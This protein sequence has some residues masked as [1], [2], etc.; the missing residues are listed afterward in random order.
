MPVVL[1]PDIA[2]HIAAV[3]ASKVPIEEINFAGELDA[4]VVDTKSLSSDERRGCIGEILGLRFLPLSGAEAGTWDIYFGPGSSGIREDGT[5]VYFPDARSID[6]EVIRYWI[7][8]SEQTP[9]PTLRARYADLAW[10]IGRLYNRTHPGEQKVQLHRA[11]AERAIDSYLLAVESGVAKDAHQAWRF[12]D[13]ALTLALE[14][15]DATLVER[16]K[17]SAFDYYRRRVQAGHPAFWWKLDDMLWGRKG[18]T[19]SSTE[20]AEHVSWLETALALH[21]KRADPTGFDPHQALDAANRLRRWYEKAGERERGLLSLRTAG[22]AF[23]EIAPSVSVLTANAWLE[24][25]HATYWA[26]GLREDAARVEAAIRARSG[27][28]EQSM[29]RLE[30]QINLPQDEL[31]AWLNELTAGSL[32]L[33]LGRIAV[34]LMSREDALREMIEAAATKAPVFAY[35]PIGIASS[36]GFTSAVVGSVGAD[37]QGRLIYQAATI[38][39]AAAPWLNQA[40][41][42]A[43]SRHQINSDKLFAFL[44]RNPFFPSHSHQ[45]L[46]EGVHAWFQSDFVKAI[47]VLVPQIEVALRQ[48]LILMGESVMRPDR[49]SGGFEAF[50][51]GKVLYT[52]AFKMRCDSTVR[53]HFLALYTDAKGLNLRNKLAHGILSQDFLGRGIANWV[54]HSLLVIASM[55][56]AN[57]APPPPAY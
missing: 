14:I 23:E 41:E 44:S 52:D 6:S 20:I 53:L 11:I 56:V 54:I 21:S 46:K 17:T 43:K 22:S 33:A 42:H 51:M 4:L 13:R 15:K 49:E 27:E 19:V 18:L 10:E 26:A 38:I 28:I 16:A 3:E 45:L 57:R 48:I 47:H 50:T 12:L 8:R 30:V 55:S 9:H 32:E 24:N 40:L 5:E 29:K 36:G 34:N 1:L 31:D 2:A 25:L 7:Q 35:L 37:M 39:G